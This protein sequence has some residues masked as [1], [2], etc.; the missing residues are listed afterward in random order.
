[1]GKGIVPPTPN[2]LCFYDNLDVL[3]FEKGRLRDNILG[4]ESL[5]EFSLGSIQTVSLLD[6]VQ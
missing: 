2:I 1:M 4:I 6:T 3:G 5:R